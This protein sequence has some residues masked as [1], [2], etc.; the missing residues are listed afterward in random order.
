MTS[1]STAHTATYGNEVVLPRVAGPV[2]G[3]GQVPMQQV[4]GAAGGEPGHDVA[5]PGG[6]LD[7]RVTN[8]VRVLW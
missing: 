6:T 8:I 7:S 3:G 2:V 1:S 4:D 5:Q